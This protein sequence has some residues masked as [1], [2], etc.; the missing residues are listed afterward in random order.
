MARL[1]S[2]FGRLKEAFEHGRGLPTLSGLTLLSM[3]VVL[4][5]TL[6]ISTAVSCTTLLETL[7]YPDAYL[8][9]GHLW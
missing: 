8:G 6:A 3:G 9:L 1:W 4:S 5:S 7:R 2:L